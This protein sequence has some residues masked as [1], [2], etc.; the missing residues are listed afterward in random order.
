[1]YSWSRLRFSKLYTIPENALITALQPEHTCY[2]V[3]N[4]RIPIIWSARLKVL[5]PRLWHNLK[6]WTQEHPRG[7]WGER[8]RWMI[9]E[10]RMTCQRTFTHM[11]AACLENE[12]LCVINNLHEASIS[13]ERS[14]LV[15][16]DRCDIYVTYMW[17]MSVRDATVVNICIWTR[18]VIRGWNFSINVGIY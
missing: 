11:S 12:Q 13:L 17:Q 1:M 9:E 7:S 6:N 15:G 4:D 5:R 16:L 14:W 18:F 10:T 3:L 2:K 8:V